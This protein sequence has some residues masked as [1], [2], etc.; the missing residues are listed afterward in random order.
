MTP[1]I[2]AAIQSLAASSMGFVL[3]AGAADKLRHR[4]RF[5][6]AVRDYQVA[7]DF[8]A[9]SAAVAVGVIEA[10]AGLMLLAPSTREIGVI[11]AA[12][13][14]LFL[15]ALIALNL[16]R[17]RRSIDCGCDLTRAGRP[18][19]WRLVARNFALAALLALTLSPDPPPGAVWLL[20]TL[21][22]LL[23]FGL[24]LSLRQLSSPT[25]ATRVAEAP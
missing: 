13:L 11:C 22:A 8:L 20:S 1:A 12:A 2:L 21:A 14:I 19:S 4:T 10:A 18:I 23:V 6:S 16:L 9:P 25:V 17:G 7:P 24:V 3:V 15:A 5:V